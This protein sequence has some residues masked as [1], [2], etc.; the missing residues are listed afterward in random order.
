MDIPTKIRLAETYAK[1][2]EAELARRLVYFSSFWAEN[3][4]RKV[5]L[6]R[7][8]KNCRSSWRQIC[9]YI[10]VSRWHKD[11]RKAPVTKCRCFNL[12]L[13]SCLFCVLL[14]AG[15]VCV[16]PRDLVR[17]SHNEVLQLTVQGLT[18]QIQ[19]IQVN[20][21]SEFM[22]KLIYCRRSYLCD[23][24]EIGLCHPAFTKEDRKS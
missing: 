5:Q 9:L 18:Y 7:P 24:G 3:E 21:V 10:S 22:I 13:G 20:P 16:Y 11:M 17:Y 12:C 19:M 4:N 23:P 8:R 15:S 14:M 2:S 1:I 6:R